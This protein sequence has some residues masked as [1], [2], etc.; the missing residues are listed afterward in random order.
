MFA[1]FQPRSRMRVDAHD[2]SCFPQLIGWAF[3]VCVTVGNKKALRDARPFPERL[4]AGYG[5][6]P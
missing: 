4:R 3:F 1:A 6:F 2:S 5:A